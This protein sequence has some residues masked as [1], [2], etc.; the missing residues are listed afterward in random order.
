MYSELF[1]PYRALGHVCDSVPFHLK[2]L[3]NATFVTV[4]IGRA[5]QVYNCEKLRLCLIGPHS[6]RKIRA[7]ASTKDLTF[8]AHGCDVYMWKRAVL[9]HKLKGHVEPVSH[10]LIFGD[11][12]L[13]VC[14]NQVLRLWDL[15]GDGEPTSQ[16]LE[17]PTS[18]RVTALMH[19]PTYL[20][21]ICVGFADGRM[22]LWNI[23]TKTRI[24]A[25]DTSKFSEGRDPVGISSIVQS[26]A[27]DVV[28]IG[29]TDGAI[30][31]HNLLVDQIVL[32]FTQANGL[33]VTTLAFRTDGFPFLLSGS[34]QGQLAVWDLNKK[35]LVDTIPEVHQG[36]VTAMQFLAGEPL[37]ITSGADNSLKMWIFDQQN[38]SARLLKS[39]EG[40]SQPPTKLRFYGDGSSILTS[41]LDRALRAFSVVR[42]QQ[43]Q[44]LSQGALV[45]KAKAYATK[46]DFL[47]L[48]E[49]AD[50][51]ASN[52]QERRWSNIVTC[53]KED[54][55]AHTWSFENKALAKHKLL[56]D[57]LAASP[58]TA[59]GISACG[60]FGIIGMADGRVEKY[61]LQSGFIRAEY[62][63][64][65]GSSE[66]VG[67]TRSVTG[68]AVDGLN[69]C[70]ISAS[71]DSTIKFWN[72][73]QKSL[74]QSI[75]TSAPVCQILFQRES[76]LLAVA[77]DDL[78]VSVYDSHTYKAV[79]LF[80]GLTHRVT[81][82]AFT[83]D[84]R[85]LVISSM[86]SCVR[87]F[88]LP[89]GRL[90]DWLAFDAAVTSLAFSPKGDFLATTHAN[91]LGIFL[92][93]NRSYFTNVFLDCVPRA[94][95]E[96]NLPV[97]YTKDQDSVVVEVPRQKR[98]FSALEQTE[99]KKPRSEEVDIFAPV[100][101]TPSPIPKE[102][103]FTFSALPKARW[104]NLTKLDLIK[105]RNKPKNPP[106]APMEAPFF[107]PTLTGLTTKLDV[108][109]IKEDDKT[110]T[111]HLIRSNAQFEESKFVRLLAASPSPENND[112]VSDYLR[113]LGP[114]AIDTD[115]R[116][117]GLVLGSEDTQLGLFL[118]WIN[119][120][121]QTKRNYELLQGILNLFLKVHGDTIA[122]HPALVDKAKLLG[123]TQ[124]A[125][126]RR[127]EKKFQF[128]NCLVAHFGKTQM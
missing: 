35:A 90:I 26:P 112:A 17:F 70:L 104:V 88:D 37:L 99:T 83:P 46:I 98:K 89:S 105:E 91:N 20:N 66:W 107:L 29:L 56:N 113:G 30:I 21:K 115:I 117:L 31:I 68:L 38:G 59:V 64:K 58:V 52:T 23:K 114:A 43:S 84:G 103:M 122:Q 126:W 79:R 6:D 81:D 96:M 34:T 24:H 75:S 18:S 45:K 73:K 8:T 4:A 72:F 42:D 123:A 120:A 7:I 92:W 62:G 14:E 101:F 80:K 124:R 125:A 27:V 121:L 74:L 102:D 94:A 44:E 110:E 40:H 77:T 106:K 33:P 65:F 11:Y 50:F 63:G 61:N 53:H 15:S 47:R 39:R 119:S 71:L 95:V 93:A 86:D 111:S 60:N 19:P 127:L 28:G 9:V 85:W 2:R 32:R 78:L 13:S 48:S 67:H 87:V 118:D 25:F 109:G 10:L 57:Q 108:S 12:L 97:Q 54:A 128:T 76:D 55:V 49:I 82:M 116:S 41:G 16:V 1:Q 22:E 3:G 51:Q 5:W 100:A 36:G 69:A